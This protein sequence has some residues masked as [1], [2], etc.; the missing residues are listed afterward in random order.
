MVTLAGIPG[1][2]PGESISLWLL[3]WSCGVKG[4]FAGHRSKV[5]GQT[6]AQDLQACILDLQQH[7]ESGAT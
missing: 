1:K 7:A 2:K 5:K 6:C 3:Q 4:Q